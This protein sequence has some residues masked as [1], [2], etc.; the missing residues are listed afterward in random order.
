MNRLIV[1]CAA[2]SVL[3]TTAARTESMSSAIKEFGL[4]GRWT[5]DC[6]YGNGEIYEA[7][8]FGSPTLKTILITGREHT[9][10]LYTIKSATRLT[11][12]KIRLTYVLDGG[13][14]TYDG[15]TKVV[16]A[17]PKVITSVFQKEGS[18]IRLVERYNEDKTVIAVIAGK[19]FI[20]NL[21]AKSPADPRYISTGSDHQLW[22]RCLN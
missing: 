11:E 6:Q 4:V 14:Q 20:P 2:A 18:K 13:K 8:F 9:E 19:I 15:L 7:P 1:L 5:F 16:P 17:D 10:T 22:E 12:E 21:Q 3:S